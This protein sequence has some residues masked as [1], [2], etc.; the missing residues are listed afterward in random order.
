MVGKVVYSIGQGSVPALMFEDISNAVSADFTLTPL[1]FPSFPM[2][3]V[4]VI[5]IVLRPDKET[6]GKVQSLLSDYSDIIVGSMGVR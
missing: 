4:G 2:L 5:G 1:S 6:A 3:R